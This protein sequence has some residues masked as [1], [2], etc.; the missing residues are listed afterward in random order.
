MKSISRFFSKIG[1][2]LNQLEGNEISSLDLNEK[3]ISDKKCIKIAN[4]LKVV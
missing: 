2:A 3:D 4:A 1:T